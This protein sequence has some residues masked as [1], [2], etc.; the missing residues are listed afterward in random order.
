MSEAH[1]TPPPRPAETAP[2]SRVPDLLPAVVLAV[3]FA[4]PAAH[5]DGETRHLRLARC[6][7][8]LRHHAEAQ[9][10]RLDQRLGGEMLAIFGAPR[11]LEQ[12]ARQAMR[13]ALELRR[14]LAR[15]APQ[16]PAAFAAQIGLAAGPLWVDADG[17][18]SGSSLERAVLLARQAAGEEILLC[19]QTAELLGRPAQGPDAFRLAGQLPLAAEPLLPFVGRQR[20]LGLLLDQFAAVRDDRARTVSI[21][22]G[23]GAG[24]SRLLLELGARLQAERSRFFTASCRPGHEAPD[25]LMR[26]L[27]GASLG[28]TRAQAEERLGQLRASPRQ[29]E[30][31]LGY[32]SPAPEDPPVSPAESDEIHQLA[33]ALIS[34]LARQ[35]PLVLVFEDLQW[36]DPRSALFLRRLLETISG[37]HLL[38]VLT[39]RPGQAPPLAAD[40]AATQLVL[41]PLS[42]AETRQLAVAAFRQQG[43][44]PQE[45]AGLAAMA[46]GNPGLAFA[47][48]R[49]AAGGE[50][51]FGVGALLL[52]R[53]MDL[54]AEAFD[55]LR[56]AAVL[57]PEVRPQLLGRML[58][59]PTHFEAS[60]SL[61]K[62][63]E[64]LAETWTGNS[65]RLVFRPRLLAQALLASLAPSGRRALHR[66]AAEILT[67]LGTEKKGGEEP[68]EHWA[69]AGETGLAARLLDEKAGRALADQDLE[70]AA[71]ALGRALELQSDA[72]SAAAFA[73]LDPLS[74]I[75]VRLDR[76]AELGRLWSSPAAGAE[77]PPDHAG[78]RAMQFWRAV[79]ALLAGERERA[80]ALAGA[81]R[82]ESESAGDA[83]GAGRALLLEASA[84]LLAGRPAPALAAAERAVTLLER[85]GDSLW[86]TAATRLAARA[87]EA[88]GETE[89][90][91]ELHRRADNASRAL[92][93]ADPFFAWLGPG[94]SQPSASS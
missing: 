8:L 91:A 69:A 67:Q 77:L 71:A 39:W 50:L 58:G 27:F 43:S 30:I 42:A 7:A 21:V 81:L 12:P 45:I 31:L 57:G 10:G 24:K 33:L 48:S 49:R 66:R 84:D 11:V 64:L 70:S 36:I 9:G 4:P 89:S 82:R 92:A 38:L 2:E 53:C 74:A 78:R 13:A 23:A 94:P 93:L 52:G 44:D 20:E 88:A 59:Q 15:E 19:P 86:Q 60:A 90:A 61:L 35:L 26:G 32:F 87:L 46:E 85:A 16:E 3:V 63:Q 76:L 51:P 40:L 25:Q 22:G 55:L 28:A 54:P 14:A 65:R 47:L 6:R 1:P 17:L 56:C 72:G 29:R 79:A 41:R 80:G 34:Q 83:G 18:A 75:L 37:E 68:I 5:L 73:R 62:R